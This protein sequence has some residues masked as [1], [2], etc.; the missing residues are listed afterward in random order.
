LDRPRLEATAAKLVD[1]GK[2][3]LAADESTGTI[4]KRF[5]AV[6]VESTT[7]TRLAYRTL[8]FTTPGL[9][10]SIGGVILF[11]ETFRSKA[12]DGRTLPELLADHGIV[13]GIKVD[14]GAKRL[15]GHADEKATEGLDGLGERLAEYEALGAGFAKW[16]AV[17]GIGRAEDGTPLPSPACLE[18][19]A[20]ALARYAAQCQEAGLVPI[21]EPEVLMDGDHGIGACERVTRRVLATV[22]D[23]LRTQDVHLSGTLLKPSMVISGVGAAERAGPDE[24][25]RRTLAVLRDCVPAS[26]PGI[27]FLSGGQGP[28]EATEHLRIMNTLGPVPWRLSFSY[29][30]AL[31]QPALQAWGGRTE[32]LEAAQATLRRRA[33]ANRAAASGRKATPA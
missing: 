23:A 11:D 6:G 13:P 26:V 7:A 22:Y 33:E 28:E 16:R 5:Q 2:G 3:I 19:N 20:Q 9:E 27:V 32:N 15:A 12:P 21:V 4:A 8:L 17:I 30:R 18:A 14:Q 29:G 24:V 1:D 25:A 10:E 31:Q